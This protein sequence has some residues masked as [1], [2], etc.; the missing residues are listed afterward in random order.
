MTP[1]RCRF[2]SIALLAVI[3]P[4]AHAW[5]AIVT[6][7]PPAPRPAAKTPAATVPAAPS[8]QK[9][10]RP[11]VHHT[12]APIDVTVS[13]LTLEGITA[14]SASELEG[15]LA[16]KESGRLPWS[17]KYAFSKEEFDDDLKRIR[18]FYAD[19]G[20]P[21]AKIVKQELQYNERKDHVAITVVIEEGPPVT[22]ASVS[23]FGFDD[24]PEST[25][26]FLQRALPIHAGD[27]RRQADL[28]AARDRAVLMLNERGFAYARV[29]A[30]EG[31]GPQPNT[32]TLTL[33]AEPGRQA[34]F[35]PL[36]ITGNSSVDEK[37]IRSQLAFGP[38]D[39]F[40][41][42][43][44]TES[45]RRLYNLELFQYVNF[46]V[47][48]LASQPAEVPVRAVITEGKHRRVQFGIGAG[49]EDKARATVSW[50]H[51]NFFGGAR[52]LSLDGKWSSLER[53]ARA[54]FIEPHFFSPSY[55]L[56]LSA[57]NWFAN[58]PAF[59]LLTRGGRASISREIV[60]R[61][62][63]RR[64]FGTTRATLSFIDEYE[65]QTISNDALNDPTFRD[66]LIALGLDPRTGEQVG[67][68]VALGFDL[69]H[70]TTRNLLDARNGYVATLHVEQAGSWLP[71]DYTYYEATW[72]GRHYFTIKRGVIA[73]RVR[74]GAIT[75]PGSEETNVPFFKRYFLGGSSSIRGWSRYQISPLS[76]SGLP[77]GGFTFLEGSSEIRFPI[78][79]N[80]TGVM[81]LDYGNVWNKA[82]DFNLNDMVYA[83]GPGI[84]YKTPVGPLRF[85]FGYQLKRIENLVVDGRPEAR[86]WRIHFSIGQAF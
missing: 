50:R 80:F 9:P 73:N 53:G 5:P 68:L 16:T 70:D 52:T 63:S 13:K 67:T 35:G 8:T 26:R 40:R 82:W 85:D 38:G 10:A 23:L 3:V 62:P 11:P 30:L 47:P 42:S 21:R 58:E 84:R 79:G 39:Q 71:G 72:E 36:E 43:R 55:K 24:L 78:R 32:V 14:V 7:A 41:M 34:K 19:R 66:E 20:Y 31:P 28:V 81:F 1:I 75:S 46:D 15:V 33:A 37:F 48:T 2:L 59:T 69:T 56:N 18:A 74:L 27:V 12:S 29:Q 51:V 65:H 77:I 64:R 25:Q 22:I 83:A 76:G 6:Q 86:R 45:Q 4:A 60:R 49:T 17:E 57:Q 44:L 61:D 54:S